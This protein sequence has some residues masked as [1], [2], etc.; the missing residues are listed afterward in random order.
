MPH[1]GRWGV[2][3]EKRTQPDG[4]PALQQ[5]MNIS[6]SS[7]LCDRMHLKAHVAGYV[8]GPVAVPTVAG[9]Q[10]SGDSC[11]EATFEP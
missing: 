5:G 6:C 3:Q 8:A 1:P 9:L 11:L 7:F 10:V 2:E 4:L